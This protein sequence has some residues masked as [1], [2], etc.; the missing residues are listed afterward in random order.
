MAG[1]VQAIGVV[2]GLLKIVQFGMD[3][4]ETQPDPGST[5]KFAIGLDSQSG[6]NGASGNLPDV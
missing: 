3:N 6:L 1:F 4:F 5:I 2:S